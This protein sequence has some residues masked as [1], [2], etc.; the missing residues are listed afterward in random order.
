MR[1]RHFFHERVRRLVAEAILEDREPDRAR[2]RL[3]SLAEEGSLAPYGLRMLAAL[4]L[5]RGEHEAARRWL[6]L[7]IEARAQGEQ[8]SD[9]TVERY[10]LAHAWIDG[11]QPDKGLELLDA[12]RKGGARRSRETAA[13]EQ[14]RGDAL[15]KLDRL[16]Q[17]R[18]AYSKSARS[19]PKDE[20]ELAESFPWLDVAYL[21]H[22]R[23]QDEAALEVLDAILAQER[24]DVTE[25]EVHR[26]R[27]ELLAAAGR[28]EEALADLRT[29]IDEARDAPAMR[30]RLQADP[31]LRALR[32]AKGFAAAVAESLAEARWLDDKPALAA[33]RGHKGLHERGVRFVDESAAREGGDAL[34]TFYGDSLHLGTLWSEALWAECRRVAERLWLLAEGPEIPGARH[35]AGI[36]VKV[37]LYVDPEQPDAIWVAPHAEF[38]AALMTRLPAE[39]DALAEGLD[40]LLLRPPAGLRELPGTARAF[41]GYLNELVV[42]SPY[43]GQME[44]AGPH[45]LDRHFNFSPSLDPLVWGGAYEDDPWPDITPAVP[46]A[47]MVMLSRER[48]GQLRGSVARLT[49]RA[50][51]SRAHIG[52]EIHHPRTQPMY[53]WHIRYRPNPFPETIERFNAACGTR[54]PTD[55]P[56]DVVAGIVGFDWIPAADLE[57]KLGEVEPSSVPAYL[58]VIAALRSNDL[59]VTALLREQAARADLGPD[60]RGA[61]AN[62]CLEYNWRALLE[63]MALVEPDEE[64]REQMLRVLAGP[65]PETEFNEMGEPVGMYGDDDDEDEDEEEGDDE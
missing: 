1:T 52:Y 2:R 53:V 47:R 29:A 20:A 42:P 19:L 46:G 15:S 40:R 44:E 56:A 9:D 26:L 17:A 31:G 25:G 14:G 34:R 11:G 32:E 55:L 49:R 61:I 62:L 51:F 36:R 5:E 48:R 63:E 13:Y 21:E 50:Q 33:L 12:L 54:Y 59:A 41:M 43:S 65:F 7:A 58:K 4:E 28:T 45:E 16:E 38:P 60:E 64:L 27:A 8:D 18:G 30:A 23:G 24:H 22:E 35:L 10:L 3:G 6:E 57:A 37:L 39:G